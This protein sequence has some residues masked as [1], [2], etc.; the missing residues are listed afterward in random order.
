VFD[1]RAIAERKI[2]EAIKDGAFDNLPGKGKPLVLD[3]DPSTPLHLRLANKVLKNA[4]VLPDWVQLN[5]EIREGAEECSRIWERTQA[6]Y[7]RRQA[8]LQ[9]AAAR[10]AD[11][12]RAESAFA[13]WYIRTHQAYVGA[14]KRVNTDIL[15]SNMMQP[16]APCVLIP[17][18]IVEETRRFEEQF[19]PPAGFKPPPQAASA[20][21][22]TLKSVAVEIYLARL[23]KRET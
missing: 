13:Q 8:R 15:K 19:P 3:D 18:R 21:P 9:D 10:P 23:R 6:E 14:M 17:Y 1:T 12:S 11:L 5:V 4:N 22:L 2:E 7:S 20:G 16:M